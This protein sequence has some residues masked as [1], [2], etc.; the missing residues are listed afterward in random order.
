MNLTFVFFKCLFIL[1]VV[2]DNIGL[3]KLLYSFLQYI[4][5]S[6]KCKEMYQTRVGLFLNKE[7]CP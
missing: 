7:A 6:S 1:Q 2:T 5:T 3:L 4:F